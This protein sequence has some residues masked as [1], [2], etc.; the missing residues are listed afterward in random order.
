MPQPRTVQSCHSSFPSTNPTLLSRGF[1]SDARRYLDFLV[2][3][4]IYARR[5]DRTRRTSLSFFFFIYYLVSSHL[6]SGV[7]LQRLV[8]VF[9]PRGCV[10]SLPKTKKQKRKKPSGSN[11]RFVTTS[12]I[13]VARLVQ[14]LN[15]EKWQ[16]AWEQMGVK[17]F[18]RN[19]S[20]I[21]LENSSIK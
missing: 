20:I 1:A 6:S 8:V 2:I 21:H 11:H 19:S 14:K 3:F 12:V 17:C 7:W 5:S 18:V 10:G 15:S 16:D 4:A 13:L 9:F